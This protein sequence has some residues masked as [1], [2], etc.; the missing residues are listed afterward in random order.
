MSQA[1]VMGDSAS[2]FLFLSEEQVGAAAWPPVT[3]LT[4]LEV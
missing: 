1:H 2:V 3:V 4:G